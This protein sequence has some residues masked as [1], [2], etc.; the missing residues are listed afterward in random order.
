MRALWN[1]GGLPWWYA[2]P[3]TWLLFKGFLLIIAAVIAAGWVFISVTNRMAGL[4]AYNANPVQLIHERNH[5]F[6]V[7]PEW[8]SGSTNVAGDGSDV[9]W[10]WEMA[11]ARARCAVVFIFWAG[12]VGFFIRQYSQRRRQAPP[13]NPPGFHDTLY[14]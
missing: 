4:R 12:S 6:L 3:L 7:R 10:R 13:A 5:I 11:E 1:Y 14:G 8:I 2:R 9:E